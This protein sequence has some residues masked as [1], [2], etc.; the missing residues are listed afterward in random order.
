MYMDKRVDWRMA[1]QITRKLV[2]DKNTFCDIVDCPSS[3]NVLMCCAQWYKVDDYYILNIYNEKEEEEG[4][5]N[6]LL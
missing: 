5:E 6:M 4:G 3:L 1:N 2:I